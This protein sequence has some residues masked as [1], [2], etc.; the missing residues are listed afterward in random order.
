MLK[1]LEEPPEHVKFILATTDPQKIPVTVL[2]R[3][4]QFN[5][6]QMTPQEIAGH[7]VNVLETEQI[8]AEIPAL[9]LIAHSAEGSMR[10]A[11]SLLDQ[12]ISHGQ[13]AIKEAEV[14][15]M[16]GAVDLDYIFEL[17]TALNNNDLAKML[18]IAENMQTR[19]L[20]FETAL[21][22]LARLF[23]QIQVAQLAQNAI[24]EDSPNRAKIIEFAQAFS[25]EYVQLAYQIA[26]HGRRD[27]GLAPDEF[28]GFA[29]SLMRLLAFYPADQAKN[30]SVSNVSS[31]AVKI[32]AKPL[33]NTASLA[34]SRVLSA[35]TL[36]AKKPIE[37]VNKE[38]PKIIEI[39]VKSAL[40]NAKNDEKSLES[41]LIADPKIATEFATEFATETLAFTLENW[42]AM[43]PKLKLTG[44][45]KQLA[46][47]CEL[48]AIAQS[49]MDF[50]V[51]PTKKSLFENASAKE[52]IKTAIAAHFGKPMQVTF[53]LETIEN[54]TPAMIIKEEIEEQN[55]AALLSIKN[56]AFVKSLQSQFD[57][58]LI[59]A[60]IK[61]I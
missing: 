5:L 23:T 31:E 54:E 33:I 18:E 38:A 57:A 45:A 11:L 4:L 25:P 34:N 61:P 46:D 28:S 26:I 52:Q 36:E 29:M 19:S 50:R 13:G 48:R 14:R 60:S 30:A 24:S 49:N 39:P 55:A 42:H 47:H 51:D 7:L 3:C 2:S 41:L 44:L 27:L 37:T 22:E 56:D 15:Q 40:D 58:N 12:A 20:S 35:A 53:H 17:L 59:E 1:T 8:P 10:D 16:L 9:N 43:L 21:Q 6:K 32:A